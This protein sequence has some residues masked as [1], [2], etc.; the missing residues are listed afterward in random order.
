MVEA[1]SE[2]WIQGREL[3]RHEGVDGMLI[4]EQF[5]RDSWWIFMVVIVLNF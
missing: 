5:E 1:I 3:A 4:L 2:K